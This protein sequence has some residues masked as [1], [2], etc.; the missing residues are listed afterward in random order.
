MEVIGCGAFLIVIVIRNLNR[1]ILSDGDY[2][3]DYDYE[4]V[5][6]RDASGNFLSLTPAPA[7]AGRS[8]P[9]LRGRRRQSNVRSFR[10]K[11]SEKEKRYEIH[12]EVI[13]HS[14]RAGR[15]CL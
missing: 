6:Q 9:G 2:D 15:V 14:L 7:A 3:Y 10:F 12:S 5:G 1:L 13:H 11:K 4:G 8:K